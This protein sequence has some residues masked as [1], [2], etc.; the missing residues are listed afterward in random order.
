MAHRRAQPD[1]GPLALEKG[2]EPHDLKAKWIVWFVVSFIVIA[3]AIQLMLWLVLVKIGSDQR[4]VD[5]PRS[6]L[7]SQLPPPSPSLQPT[8]HHD[9]TPPQ[10]LEAMRKHED[11]VFSQ[12]GW[13]VNSQ[14]HQT[15]VPDDVV[16]RVARDRTG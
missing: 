12:L 15:I 6:V 2:Y 10:D 1:P 14:T 4:F 9:A 7:S 3:A 5:Q 13:D 8:E 16:N 11:A